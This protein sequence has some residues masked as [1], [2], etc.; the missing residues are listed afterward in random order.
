MK[1]FGDSE[2]LP[3]GDGHLLG[4]WG[5][6][7]PETLFEVMELHFKWDLNLT[8]NSSVFV[9]SKASCVTDC[10]TSGCL[11]LNGELLSVDSCHALNF[12][13]LNGVAIIQAV[14]FVL[15]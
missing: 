14:S 12:P 2:F 4:I 15:M 9:N 3:T 10:E 8:C 1:L 11:D 6:R 7:I 5:I 13:E